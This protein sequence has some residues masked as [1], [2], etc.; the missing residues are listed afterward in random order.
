M[1]KTCIATDIS[2]AKFPYLDSWC[3][4]LYRTCMRLFRPTTPLL[5]VVLI[6]FVKNMYALECISSTPSSTFP[7]MHYGP[8]SGMYMWIKSCLETIWIHCDSD[9]L[10][11]PH[12]VLI[13]HSLVNKQSTRQ[14]LM[15]H[16]WTRNTFKVVNYNLSRICPNQSYIHV[17]DGGNVFKF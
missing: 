6:I 16:A 14:Y 8:S 4:T 9:S 7:P 17:L 12:N 11:T 3:Q 5:S 10:T 1:F 15:R 13:F 2:C